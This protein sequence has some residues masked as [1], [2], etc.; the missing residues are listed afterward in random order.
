MYEPNS[1]GLIMGYFEDVYLK[2]LN[3]YGTNHQERVQGQREREFENYLKKSVYKVDFSVIYPLGAGTLFTND[4]ITNPEEDEAG[5]VIANDSTLETDVSPSVLYAELQ[6]SFD[7]EAGDV[8]IE[9]TDSFLLVSKNLIEGIEYDLSNEYIGILEPYKQDKTQTLSYLLT[10]RNVILP[11]GYVLKTINTKGDERNWI[12]WWMEE[13]AATGYNRYVV[14]K[15]N[16]LISW[17]D[18]NKIKYTQWAHFSGP[19]SQKIKDMVQSTKENTVYL[20]NENLYMFITTATNKINKNSY[21]E[22][23]VENKEMAY[24]VS[25]LDC[26]STKGIVYVSINPT[27]IRDKTEKPTQEETD[28]D[29]D[30]FWLNKGGN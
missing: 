22:V 17:E 26:L 2:R 16:Q 25:G 5:Y 13:I 10:R 27:Y 19:G 30:F 9:E 29:S 28:S 23:S 4:L 20:E 15:A 24:S 14:M 3:R 11:S 6:N 1:E 18:E 8:E 7:S 12:I 21:I